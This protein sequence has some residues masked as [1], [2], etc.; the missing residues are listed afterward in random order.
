ML[1]PFNL[2]PHVKLTIS[3]QIIHLRTKSIHPDIN[4]KYEKYKNVCHGRLMP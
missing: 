3:Y 1:P 4:T 2:Y